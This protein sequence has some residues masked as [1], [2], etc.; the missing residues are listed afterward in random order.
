MNMKIFLCI[1]LLLANSS[2]A[3]DIGSRIV[4]RLGL[5]VGEVMVD[6]QLVKT[7]AKVR[8]S[9]EIETKD[10]RTTLLLGAGSVFHIAANS[11][12]LVNQFTKDKEGKESADL[13]LK[14]GK[15]RGLVLDRNDNDKKDVKLRARSATMGIRGTEVLVDVPKDVSKPANFITIE[16]RTEV[17]TNTNSKPVEVNAGETVSSRESSNHTNT[18]DGNSANG[19]GSNA[20]GG[21]NEGGAAPKAEK[22]DMAQ[23]N[24][25]IKS[26][27]MSAPPPPNSA[28]DVKAMNV[29]GPAGPGG[30]G[31]KLPPPSLIADSF[32][33]GSI[34]QVPFDA[35]VDGMRPVSFDV[36]LRDAT[37]S[38]E[39]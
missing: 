31:P 32:G 30:Q 39:F 29:A 23:V 20:G 1:L 3:A 5:V 10:G 22:A 11:K 7:G 17:A 12:M 27:G 35:T 25:D 9:S 4:G 26:D 13:E 8:E 37:N 33:V 21:S 2:S 15:T 24:Q 16:G 19:S 14:F 6:G 38:N 36:I 18:S 34:P 28:G